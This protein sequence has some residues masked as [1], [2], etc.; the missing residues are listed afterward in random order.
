MAVEYTLAAQ[1]ADLGRE[2]AAVDLEIIGQ[3]LTVEGNL[4]AVAV[5]FFCLQHEIGHQLFPRGSLGDDL[6]A[7]VKGD[8]LEGEILHHIEDELLMEAAIVGTGVQNVAAVDQ[9]D[10]AGL[11]G[12]DG[13]G[14]LVG[15]GTGKLLG[16]YLRD[17]HLIEQ[18][19]VAVIID[20]NDLHRPR[21][22]D[23]DMVDLIALGKNGVFFV[24]GLHSSAEAMEH[25]IQI[26][27]CNALKKG[28]F[29]ENRKIIF[30]FCAYP[31]LIACFCAG[32][33]FPK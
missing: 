9:H 14:E 12:N 26:F 23:A 8:G 13:D 2:T 19:A 28:A 17:G 6:G 22:D 33:G 15:L 11:V 7:M 24:K 21:E 3:L 1:L 31:F 32:F 20:L 4:K 10:L 5:C 27:V 29:F 18:R 25:A 16:K 30:Q